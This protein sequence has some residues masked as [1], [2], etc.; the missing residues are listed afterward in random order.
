M[1][2][3]GGGISNSLVTFD[4][5]PSLMALA[6]LERKLS[7]TCASVEVDQRATCQHTSR[8]QILE[9]SIDL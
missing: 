6:R 2:G 1:G 9:E 3:G 8:T 7:K 5:P 4:G